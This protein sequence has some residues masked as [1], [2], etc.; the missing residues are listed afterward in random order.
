MRDAL[1]QFA[2]TQARASFDAGEWGAALDWLANVPNNLQPRELVLKANDALSKEAVANGLWGIAE[3]HLQEALAVRREP[4]L[5]RRLHLVRHTAPL[6]DDQ[7]WLFLRSKA[8][9]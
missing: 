9:P 5:E 8:D 7:R 1:S 2:L 4:L 3:D 6:L